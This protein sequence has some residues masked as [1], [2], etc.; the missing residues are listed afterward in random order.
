MLMAC[1]CATLF[2]VPLT[3]QEVSLVLRKAREKVSETHPEMD[4]A[5]KKAVMNSPG[6]LTYHRLSGDVCS[7]S[8]T[9]PVPP[10]RI[11]V[12]QGTGNIMQLSGARVGVE[13]TSGAGA[14]TR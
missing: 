3:R 4:S 8:I 1:G 12:V 11:V 9:W 5:T 14:A 10:D 6:T 2:D 7:Y 13:V